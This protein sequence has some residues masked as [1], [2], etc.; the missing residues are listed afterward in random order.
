MS[1]TAPAPIRKSRSTLD[2]AVFAAVAAM[3]SM[4][5]F[6]LAQQLHSAPALAAAAH[7]PAAEQA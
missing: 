7:S 1:N 4:N 2:R 6:V 5:L 3:V